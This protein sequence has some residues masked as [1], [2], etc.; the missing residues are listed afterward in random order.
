MEWILDG[1]IRPLFEEESTGKLSCL[2]EVTL[3]FL[4]TNRF[5]FYPSGIECETAIL[6]LNIA[7]KSN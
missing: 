5:L 6:K 2:D 1:E 7:N 3:C 4:E